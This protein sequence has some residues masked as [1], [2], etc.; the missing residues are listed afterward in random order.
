MSATIRSMPASN[1][2]DLAS[3]ISGKRFLSMIRREYD[4]TIVLERDTQLVVACLCRLVES[5]RVRITSEDHGQ[6]FG[7]PPPIDAAAEINRRIAGQ[8]VIRAELR[9]GTLDLEL[10]LEHGC[11]LQVIADSSGYEAWTVDCPIGQ[12]I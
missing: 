3:W 6:Q 1:T 8:L 2:T 10:H 9:E 5:G 4:W 7:L 12:F 11:C